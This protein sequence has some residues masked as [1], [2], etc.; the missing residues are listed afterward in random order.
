MPRRNTQVLLAALLTA[1]LALPVLPA[2]AQQASGPSPLSRTQFGIGYVANAP[3]ATVGASAYVLGT[4]WGGLGLYVDA[5]FDLTDPSSER[6][7]DPS[8]TSRQVASD[9]GGD[10]LKTEESWW[11][12]NLALVRPLTPSLMAYAGAG[13]AT[14]T[15]FDLYTVDEAEPVGLGGVVWAEDPEAAA[16]RA[17]LMV[18]VIMR[19]T[20]RVSTHFG[21]E[22]RPSGVTVGASLRV[23]RW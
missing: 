22:T 23:P 18:G 19:I 11:S 4:R 17:N 8:V 21:Y 6:G 1:S 13:L 15:S 20:P 5:K 14:V 2:A 12:V 10:F 7:F 9:V 3:D 16:T